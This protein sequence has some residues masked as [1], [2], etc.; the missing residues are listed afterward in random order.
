MLH[1]V[2]NAVR[3]RSIFN[4]LTI[5]RCIEFDI[6]DKQNH[7]RPANDAFFTSVCFQI[8]IIMA[9]SVNISVESVIE[10]VIQE[11]TYDGTEIHQP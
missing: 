7:F 3:W 4:R 9:Q 10:N 1:L 11:I 6:S 2:D 5:E 8:S